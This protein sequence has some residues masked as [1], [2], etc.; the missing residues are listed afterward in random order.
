MNNQTDTEILSEALKRFDIIQTAESH[1]RDASLQDMKFAY[2]VEEGQWDELT[3][4]KRENGK[5]PRPCLTANK[6]G[7]FIARVSNAERENRI[8]GMVVPES[9]D[10]T[11]QKAKII[12][13]IITKIEH[14]SLFEE[15]YTLAGEHAISGGFGYWRILTQFE[16]DK[17]DQ[18]IKICPI[19][20]PF[21]VYYDPDGQYCFIRKG[22][23]AEEFKE[24]FPNAKTTTS[25]ENYGKGDD[26][27][28][29]WHSENMIYIAEYFVVQQYQKTILQIQLPSG[30]ITTRSTDYIGKINVPKQLEDGSV[31]LKYRTQNCD[32]VKWYKITGNEILESQDWPGK[33]IPVIEVVGNKVCVGGKTYKKSLIRDAKDMQSMYNYWLTSMTEKIALSPKAPYLVTKQE[34]ANYE[35]M[36]N[37]ANNELLPYLLYNAQGTRIPRREQPS[38][39]DAG[40]MSMLGIVDR[41][42][43]DVLGMYESSVGD[44]SNE[45]SGRAI[46][47]RKASSDLGVYM[48]HDNLSRAIIKST[49]IIVDLISKIYDTSRIMVMYNNKGEINKFEINSNPDNDIRI[50]RYEFVATIKPYST[51]RQETVA[52]IKEAMQYAPAI[53]HKLAPL[54]F[55]NVDSPGADEIVEVLTDASN[56]VD[57]NE[58]GGVA[59]DDTQKLLQEAMQ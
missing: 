33:Y 26:L 20:N 23:T 42:I 2:N 58:N 15:I 17:F 37:N 7:K 10:S 59:G 27:S 21:S 22:F 34:I 5:N 29:W 18:I 25:F 43:K 53:S 44:Q 14:D 12:Q 52:L 11:V 47:A 1:I 51:Q 35:S 16:E 36:W 31:I 57:N 40:A 9:S 19:E 46:M 3:R 54:L 30:E 24:Q 55:K 56:V 38:F 4:V 50:G 45:R 48:F 49:R 32:K 41:D 8:G 6:L 28:K 39:V 13:D